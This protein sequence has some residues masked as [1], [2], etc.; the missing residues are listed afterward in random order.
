MDEQLQKYLQEKYAEQLGDI[1]TGQMFANLGDVIGGQKVGTTS[2]FF[3]EQRKLAESQ[4]L[5]EIDK[6]RD[7]EMKKAQLAETLNTK[8]MQLQQQKD[9]AQSNNEFRKLQLEQSKQ[10]AEGN[11]EIRKMTMAQQAE[12]RKAKKEELS[13]VQAKQLG[14]AEM[15]KTAA[16]QYE[17]AIKKGAEES[18]W[19][20]YDPTSYSDWLQSQSWTPA[21]LKS[22]SAKEAEAA[23]SVWVENYLRDASGAA[24]PPSER[25]AYAKDYFEVPGDTPEIVANKAALRAQKEK[26]AVIGA[27]PGGKKFEPSVPTLR[28]KTIN[29]KFYSPS[30]NQTKVIYSD[31]TEE[32]LDGKQ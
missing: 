23:K 6:A 20:K 21:F 5:G 29:K 2:P 13:S 26:N 8:L 1:N 22:A 27:G 25:L 28:P 10:I 31:G 15:G 30:K 11:Q 3:T 7:L 18:G 9:Q 14:L 12:E 32:V 17:V 19:Q 4:T 16:G 24:I